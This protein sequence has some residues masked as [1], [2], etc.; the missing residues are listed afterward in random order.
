MTTE[1]SGPAPRRAAPFKRGQ[2][3]RPPFTRRHPS[4]RAVTRGLAPFKR[5]PAPRRGMLR[6]ESAR[7]VARPRAAGFLRGGNPGSP[8]VR[9]AMGS[10]RLTGRASLGVP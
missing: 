5:G 6:R 2:T 4:R 7:V 9:L 10:R 3:S 8:E 1:S